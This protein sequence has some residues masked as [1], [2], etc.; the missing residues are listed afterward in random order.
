MSDVEALSEKTFHP[1]SDFL[2]HDMGPALD[3][4]YIEGSSMTSEW[5]TAPLWGLGLSSDS[6]GGQLFLLHDGRATSIEDAIIFHGGESA[7][8]KEAYMT[9]SETEKVRIIQF[10]ESL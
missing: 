2:L 6:Q 9:L 1:Y 8:S 3:D 4:G 7:T 10:L 5:R